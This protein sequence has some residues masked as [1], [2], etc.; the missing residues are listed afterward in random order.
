MRLTVLRGCR[1]AARERAYELAGVRHAL[2]ERLGHQPGGGGRR[3]GPPRPGLLLVGREEHAEDVEAG[4]TVDERV[5]GLGEDREAIAIE[6][7]HEPHLPQRPV[8]AQVVR[9]DAGGEH[10]QLVVAARLRER[11]VAHVVAQVEALVVDPARAGLGERN[12]RDALPVTRHQAEARLDVGQQPLVWRWLPGE[13]QHRRHVHVRGRI[14]QLQ[15]RCIKRAE[16]V[17]GHFSGAVNPTPRCSLLLLI[18]A[19]SDAPG[20]GAAS[21]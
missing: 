5:V 1:A 4:D 21:R 20:A 13:D 12:L 2:E 14:L 8:A 11:G 15:E 17:F 10:L 6:A 19:H 18:A 16:P 3:L 9:E 7:L